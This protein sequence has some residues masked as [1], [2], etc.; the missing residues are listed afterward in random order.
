MPSVA[1]G[2]QSDVVFSKTGEGSGCAFP[3]LA[4]TG[5]DEHPKVSIGGIGVVVEGDK[6]GPHDRTPSCTPDLRVLNTFSSKVK[7][8][9]KGL[10]RIGDKY[11]DDNRIITGSDKVFA[12]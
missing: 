11:S 10:A 12:G 7:V 2:R 9:G 3:F 6:V 5:V 8:G 1:R 4:T